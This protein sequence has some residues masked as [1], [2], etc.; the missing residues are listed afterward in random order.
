MVCNAEAEL[1][2]SVLRCRELIV[3]LC[4]KKIP[5][6]RNALDKAAIARKQWVFTLPWEQPMALAVSAT[7]I[8]SQ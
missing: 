1:V 6:A 4:H 7:S 8:S 2:G 3:L 5:L